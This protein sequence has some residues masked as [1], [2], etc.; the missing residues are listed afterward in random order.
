MVAI[1]VAI[2]IV[3]NL[4]T[5][6]IGFLQ[7]AE[8][9]GLGTLVLGGGE[10]ELSHAT[11]LADEGGQRL[12]FASFL[13]NAHQR[14]G[15]LGR[16][17]QVFFIIAASLDEGTVR[18]VGELLQ[19]CIEH[20]RYDSLHI[21]LDEVVHVL[22]VLGLG[23]VVL[24]EDHELIDAH[25]LVLLE[26]IDGLVIVGHFLGHHLRS[27]GA[28]LDA[29]EELLHL[30]LEVVDVDV[31]ND[32][33]GL[34]VRTIPLLVVL[35]QGL[36]LEVVD[37]AHQSDRHAHTVLRAG[38]HLGQGAGDHTL[39]G[40]LTQSPLIVDDVALLHDLVLLEQ[41]SVGPV[42]EDE[43]AGVEGRLT[44]GGNI[45]DAIDGLVDRGIGIQ[46]AAKLHAERTCEL[47]EIVAL[48]VLRAVEGHVLKEV[49]QSALAL[50]LLDGSHSLCDV[51]VC[52]MFWPLVVADVVSESVV[53]FADAYGFVYGDG[54]HLGLCRQG[55]CAC[56]EE[57]GCN[58]HVF[59]FHHLFLKV[60]IKFGCKGT[61]KN[62]TYQIKV[63][64]N[65]SHL[66]HFRCQK[67]AE[68]RKSLN[69]A[70][71]KEENAR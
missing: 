49:C 8:V 23:G 70:P 47:D 18:I 15:I 51:E 69:F 25:L 59:E 30:L 16:C 7:R 4:G 68:C 48:E 3:G 22:L 50:L 71:E 6:G 53:K 29:A 28:D 1:F 33:D 45:A 24:H 11:S 42:L 14:E 21:D 66:N 37:D 2:S 35:L 67:Y 56:H 43:H 41:Q 60:S 61:T 26:D 36:G 58:E 19:T 46:V 54:R 12:H 10:S 65:R 52:H 40:T 39:R 9:V 64:A 63:F 32:D 31:A 38:V 27:L 62:D 44:R 13:R 17:Q 5:V 57:Q 34:I 55:S 20:I